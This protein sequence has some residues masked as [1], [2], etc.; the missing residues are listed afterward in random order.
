MRRFIIP[1]I[2]FALLACLNKATLRRRSSPT[3]AAIALKVAQ[4]LLY[5]D[6]A[7]AEDSLRSLAVGYPHTQPGEK[8]RFYL[9]QAL[10]IQGR[11][12]KALRQFARFE[13]SYSVKQSILRPLALLAQGNCL[14]EMGRLDDAVKRYLELPERY[15]E[16]GIG[17]DVYFGAARCLMLLEEY[18][19]ATLIYR[20]IMEEYPEREYPA[21]YHKAAGEVGKIDALRNI[22]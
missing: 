12:R 21:I 18:D 9:G 3:E 10:F 8:S 5:E 4:E 17:V 13:R 11:Y 20:M 19:R 16:S 6:A 15:P 14:E 2:A 7:A 1:L 22:F